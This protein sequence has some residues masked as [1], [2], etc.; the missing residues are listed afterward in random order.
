LAYQYTKNL[1]PA[2]PPIAMLN[3]KTALKAAGWTVLKSSDGLTFNATGDQITH[4][5]AG[6]GGMLNSK[7]WFVIQQPAAVFGGQRQLSFQLL[8]VTTSVWANFRIKYSYNAGFVTGSPAI[9][10]TPSASD[11][12]LL[13]GSGTD[14]APGTSGAICTGQSSYGTTAP[15][16]QHVVCNNASPYEFYSFSHL[17]GGGMAS[18]AIC[19][20]PMLAGSFD[21]ADV[22]PYIW[23][24]DGDVSPFTFAANSVR[25]SFKRGLTGA[26]WS[27]FYPINYITNSAN[28]AGNYGVNAYSLKDVLLPIFFGRGNADTTAVGIKGQSS[29]FKWCSNA[30]PTGDTLSIL[31]PSDAICAMGVSP[32]SVALPWDGTTPV[33]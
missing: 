22:D 25:G 30:R 17:Q 14:A 20:D 3:I 8:G 32:F 5:G 23:Y 31:T 12:L 7:A 29:L 11:E 9:L 6:A 24:F 15:Q 27:T 26:L 28:F 21:A 19:C 10:V 13:M 18:M 4:G 16:R 33:V 1:T 2:S